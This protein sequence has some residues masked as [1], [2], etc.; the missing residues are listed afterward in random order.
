MRQGHEDLEEIV[1]RAEVDELVRTVDALGERQRWDDLLALRDLCRDAQVGG[2]QLWP[3]AS[4]AEYRLALSAPASLA[5]HVLDDNTGFATA[6]PLTEVIAQSHRWADLSRHLRPGPTATLVAHERVIRGEMVDDPAIDPDI[7]ELPVWLEPWEPVYPVA[8]YGP[9]AAEFPTPQHTSRKDVGPPGTP[10]EVIGDPQ[11]TE[12]FRDL[13]RP[14]TSQSNGTVDVL[15]T[16]GDHLS[17]IAAFG[18]SNVRL[19]PLAFSEALAHL[20]WAGASGGA[21]GRRRGAAYGR[22]AAW[23]CVAALCGLSE[24]WPVPPDDLRDAGGMLRWFLWEDAEPSTGWQL[25]LAVHDPNEELG[26]AVIAT[27]HR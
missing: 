21:H 15:V 3:I 19:A 26:I 23:W 10:G 20:A 16:E 27:D 8:H 12:A 6:G 11:T 25:R 14:W 1:D 2:R 22:F 18:V 7:L 24:E 13:V 17:A 4:L 5:C 9:T